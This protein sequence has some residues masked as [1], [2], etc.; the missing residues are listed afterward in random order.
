[1]MGRTRAQFQLMTDSCCDLPHH[2]LKKE[3][4]T[5]IPMLVNID[6]K[7]Y[8]DDSGEHFD[9]QWF[10]E[11]IIEGKTPTTSQI[12]VG[13]YLE[14]F[15][16][17][18]DDDKPLLYIAFSSGL[19]G[20]YQ[21]AVMALNQLEEEYERKLP[22]T[23][24]D[25]KAACLGEGLLVKEVVHLR[26]QGKT[27]AEALEWLEYY[28]PKLH[29]WVTVDDLKH[30]EKGGRISKAQA[31]MGSLMSIK[32][33]IVMNEE[34]KLVS[35]GKIRGRKKSVERLVTETVNGIVDPEHQ[36]ILIAHAD[37]RAAA[38]AIQKSLLEKITV[39]DIQ[40]F[41]MGPTISSHTGARALAVFSFG[42][43][44]KG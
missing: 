41:Q 44:R 25:S 9:P 6:G 13:T 39:K 19:S 24:F 43:D 38:E 35:I 27:L 23:I 33:L 28:A 1:M 34:G 32:P 26:N 16:Q 21:N 12:N 42:Q 20:S 4:V 14:T 37:D 8:L 11:Q 22:I 15:K 10:I 17:F 3:K 18:I 36:T 29:S 2:F 40:I 7:E 5:C 30:L 31:T